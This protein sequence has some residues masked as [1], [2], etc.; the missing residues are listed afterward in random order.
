[1]YDDDV[2]HKGYIVIKDMSKK[3]GRRSST[4][5][6]MLGEGTCN[7]KIINKWLSQHNN[8]TLGGGLPSWSLLFT[9]VCTSDLMIVEEYIQ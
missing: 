2:I 8:I 4:T 1:M 5:V 6:V 7:K 9:Y 3:K